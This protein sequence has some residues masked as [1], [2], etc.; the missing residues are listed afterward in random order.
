MDPWEGV[1]SISAV[2]LNPEEASLLGV[3]PFG[4][5]MLINQVYYAASGAPL[6][7]SKV[8]IRADRYEYKVRFRKNSGN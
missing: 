7:C 8:L 1:Q 6:W 3:D 4:A 5:A 2:L